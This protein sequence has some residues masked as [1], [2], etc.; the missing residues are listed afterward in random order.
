MTLEAV[1][2]FPLILLVLIAMMVS[3]L[4]VSERAFYDYEEG[5]TFL[6]SLTNTF[7]HKSSI[8]SYAGSCELDVTQGLLGDVMRYRGKMTEFYSY[9]PSKILY[10]ALLGD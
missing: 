4:Q 10:G 7:G 9:K 2:I 5:V 1:I 8:N 3:F 6:L